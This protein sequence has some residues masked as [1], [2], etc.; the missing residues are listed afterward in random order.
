[1]KPSLMDDG[2]GLFT[3]F[4]EIADKVNRLL[5]DENQ[6]RVRRTLAGLEEA[7]QRASTVAKKARAESGG[8]AR[9]D[10]RCERAR[11]PRRRAWLP[12]RRA[13]LRMRAPA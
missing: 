4:A 11:L 12:R 2:E 8:H 10:N 9:A 6:G 13:W 1:M 7:T 3:S 5:D